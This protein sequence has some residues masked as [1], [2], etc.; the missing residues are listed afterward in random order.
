[1]EKLPPIAK[2]YEAFTCIA[3]NRIEM[4]ENEAIV[5]S[6]DG[7]KKYT[8][9]WKNNDFASNDNATFWQGYPGYPVLAVLMLQ[10]KLSYKEEIVNLF[11]NINWHALN[12]KYK[13]NYDAA[14]EEVLSKINY[15]TAI[16]KDEVNKIYEEIKNLDIHIK[17]KIE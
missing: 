15:D 9:K 13:R 16:I 10:N 7:K 14:V 2:I 3:D 8:I 5:S 6:S 1:M 17:R 12:E 11:T 4:K